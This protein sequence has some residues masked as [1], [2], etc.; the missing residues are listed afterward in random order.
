MFS[1]TRLSFEQA[2]ATIEANRIKLW[3][4]VR[5]QSESNRQGWGGVGWGAKISALFGTAFKDMKYTGI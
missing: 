3:N 4:G 2:N 1:R 5:G